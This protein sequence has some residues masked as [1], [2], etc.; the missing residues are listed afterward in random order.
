MRHQF[1][2]GFTRQLGHSRQPLVAQALAKRKKEIRRA[3]AFGHP[4]V[5]KSAITPLDPAL[6]TRPEG[7]TAAHFQAL[8]NHLVEHHVRAQMPVLM[9]IDVS[10]LLAIQPDKLVHLRLKISL[11]LFA[12]EGVIKDLSVFTRAHELHDA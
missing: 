3:I 9:A 8:R 5:E 7:E 10:R 12:E 4:T 1:N 11:K 6:L 2:I